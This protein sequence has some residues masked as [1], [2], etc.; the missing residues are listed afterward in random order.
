MTS[1][2]ETAL[3][4]PRVSVVIPA[5]NASG[6]IER[7]ISSVQAQTEQNFEI[8][9]VNDCS[10][11]DTATIVAALKAKDSRIRLV[12]LDRNGGP[13]VARN[14]GFAEARGRWIAILDADDTYRPDRLAVLAGRAE[15]QDLDFVADNIDLF[16]YHAGTTIPRVVSVLAND[17][18]D[19]VTLTLEL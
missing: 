19:Y 18:R 8:I 7:A 17:Q 14:R 10:T 1:P 2:A 3:Q 15:A 12:N 5:F 9:I 16:D 13:S 4:E 6:C 11:D